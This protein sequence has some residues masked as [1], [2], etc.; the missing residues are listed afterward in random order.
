MSSGAPRELIEHS[1]KVG[2]DLDLV[3]ASGGNTSCKSAGTVW[4]KGSG[5]RL[6][7]AD[8][9]EIFAQIKYGELSPSQI[10]SCPDFTPY[11]IGAAAPS[12]EA[13]FHILIEKT[14]VTH[15]HSLAAIAI[16]VLKL[17]SKDFSDF[18]AKNR[19]AALNYSRPGVELANDISL[20]P[21]FNDFILLLENHGVIFSDDNIEKLELNIRSFEKQVSDFISL[22][23]P[24]DYLPGW[25]DILTGGVLTPDEAVFLGA[26]PFVKS[27]EPVPNFINIKSD[28][29]LNFP[30][31]T[32]QD[33][34][35]LAHFYSRVAKLIE[36]K[37]EIRYLPKEEVVSLLN[38]D[39][40]ILRIAMS[41]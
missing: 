38:W 40:E 23:P 32:T 16:G 14:Y 7:D 34:I 31:G 37:A 41:K 4:V 5:M 25:I 6:K 26:T 15:L 33:R 8:S 30:D 19:I 39:K 29:T 17:P 35:D 10:V 11:S 3:Q 22:I 1:V 13:N 9:Q 28:G 36:H 12:I 20:V 2:S 27:D 21:G 18:C 24:Q